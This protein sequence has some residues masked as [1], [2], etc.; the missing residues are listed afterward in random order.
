MVCVSG[1]RRDYTR[2]MIKKARLLTRQTLARRD[3]LIPS[4][5]AAS[6]EA[7]EVHTAL[8]VGRSPLEKDLGKRKIPYSVS[9]LRETPPQR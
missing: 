5:A 8:R 6:V 3:A 9:D 7:K 4:K 2:R 1:T